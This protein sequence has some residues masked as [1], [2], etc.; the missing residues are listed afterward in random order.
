VS[1]RIETAPAPPSGAALHFS[2]TDTGI[3]IPREKQ[4]MIFE[5]FA[6]ADGSITRQYG[7]T[8]LG[9]AITCQLVE[10][11]KGRLWVE[12]PVHVQGSEDGGPGSSFHFSIP[13]RSETITVPYEPSPSAPIRDLPV[14]VVDDNHTN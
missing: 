11:M 7:G 1:V 5:P 13:L 2:V 14:L 10:L 8:G 12:S 9:L 6:Q 4:A 3:C